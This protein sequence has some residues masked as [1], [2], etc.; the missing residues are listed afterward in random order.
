MS[1]RLAGALLALFYLSGRFSLVATDEWKPYEVTP[2]EVRVWAL[3]AIVV[4]AFTYARPRQA[5]RQQLYHASAQFVPLVALL[6]ILYFAASFLWADD[7]DLA[8]AKA[9]EAILLSAV[10]FCLFPFLKT[11]R[12]PVV[13]HWFWIALVAIACVMCG[14]G[15]LTVDSSRISVL[16]GGPNT[17]G[18]NMGLLFLGALYFQRRNSYATAWRLYPLMVLALLMV[19]LSGS[20]GALLATS[21]GGFLYLLIDR[22][23]RT[24]NIVVI[25]CFAVLLNGALI[26]TDIGTLATEMFE[27]RIVNQTLEQQNMS[28]REDRFSAAFELGQERPWFGH[29]LAGFTILL[30]YNYPHNIVLEL[31]CESGIVGVLL[32]ALFLLSMLVFA[33]RHRSHCDP[34]TWGAFGLT[35]TSAMFSGDFFDSRGIF[36]I[37]MLCSQEVFASRVP[38]QRSMISVPDVASNLLRSYRPV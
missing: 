10:V 23:T 18:R 14:M 21:V 38:R 27:R 30:G 9:L 37:A 31:F 12:M 22:G 2:Y 33:I 1:E 11:K 20:R 7:L 3:L 16:G 6:L 5:Q 17:F 25:G 13:R 35:L 34:A 28:G 4:V 32:F 8:L 36:L 26:I 24:R 15:C 19:V 29:G